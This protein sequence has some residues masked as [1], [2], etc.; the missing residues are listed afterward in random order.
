MYQYLVNYGDCYSFI[1]A[2]SM[3]VEGHYA[4][5]AYFGS[6]MFTT[7]S[8]LCSGPGVTWMHAQPSPAVGFA[9]PPPELDEA[10][11][12]LGYAQYQM[13][14]GV[15]TPAELYMQG[16]SLAD[17]PLSSPTREVA[18][19][20]MGREDVEG[21]VTGMSRARSPLAQFQLRSAQGALESSSGEDEP[22]TTT[23]SAIPVGVK[24]PQSK[25]Y[26]FKFGTLYSCIKNF[27]C[28][29]RSRVPM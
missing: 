20:C 2:E 11:T 14:F 18:T 21:R 17:T 12:G 1:P 8:E 23:M 5:S 22:G 7:D 26:N 10:A 6:P 4:S 15:R 19:L 28:I 3:E 13:S 24:M 29:S 27:F 16:S 25:I 9:T